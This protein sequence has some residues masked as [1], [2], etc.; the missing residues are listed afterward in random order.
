MKTRDIMDKAVATV[1]D[2]APTYGNMRDGME[3]T[4]TIAST[5]LGK[6]IT[7]WDCSVI[8]MAIKMSRISATNNHQDSY[9]DL[10]A[11]TAFAAELTGND[12]TK[13]DFA[14][15]VSFNVDSLVTRLRAEKA[16]ESA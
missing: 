6:E 14:D 9:V 7:A 4:A 13:G 10:I 2:R 1:V 16:A 12:R 3:K 15:S 5:I 8:M 11:Y